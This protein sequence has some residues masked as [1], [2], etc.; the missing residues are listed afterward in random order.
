MQMNTPLQE[1][2]GRVSSWCFSMEVGSSGE[3][4]MRCWVMLCEVI[5]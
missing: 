2:D 1:T 3:A 5:T 4:M